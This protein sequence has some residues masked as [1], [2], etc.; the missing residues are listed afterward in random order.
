MTPRYSTPIALDPSHRNACT[1]LPDALGSG[2]VGIRGAMSAS[3]AYAIALAADNA[4]PPQTSPGYR[5]YW[6]AAHVLGCRDVTA[7]HDAFLVA[8]RHTQCDIVLDGDPSVALRHILVRSCC[9]DDGLPTLSVLDLRTFDGFE[10]SDGTVQRSI[11]AKGVVVLRVGAFRLVALPSDDASAGGLPP[12]LGEREE[13]HPYR[14]G[15]PRME[16]RPHDAGNLHTRITLLP[17]I[18]DV[19]DAVRNASAQQTGA[20]ELWLRSV[21]GCASIRIAASEL[22]RGIVIG[23]A[24]KCVDEGLRRVLNMGISRVHV[25]LLRDRRG[26]AAY[27]VASTQGTYQRG[28]WVRRVALSDEGTTLYLGKVDPIELTWRATG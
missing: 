4:R 22:D 18:S 15:A 9:L 1:R 10:L 6:M 27:D 25:L 26:A 8:G 2:L 3:E 20:Y 17:R 11:V 21:A 7:G 13:V 19:D 28:A 23:R 14:I 5:V 24:P 12:T 16:G